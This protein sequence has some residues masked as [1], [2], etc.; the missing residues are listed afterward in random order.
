MSFTDIFIAI[1]KG[2][3]AA[4]VHTHT[5]SE[6]GLGNV[7]NTADSTKSV[8]YATSAGSCTGNSATA[9]KATQDGNGNNIVNTYATKASLGTQVVATLSGTTLTITTK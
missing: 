5:K 4:A 6:V 8:K 3:V 9:T 1:K 7:D 2:I